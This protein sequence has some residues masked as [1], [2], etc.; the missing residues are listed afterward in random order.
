MEKTNRNTKVIVIGNPGPAVI[1]KLAEQYPDGVVVT[2]QTPEPVPCGS[3][4]Y[5]GDIAEKERE[6]II[7]RTISP[8]YFPP[9]KSKF[10][11]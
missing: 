3:T 4:T 9:P 7:T 8:K 10:H 6:L 11:K 1:A 5:L 2:G